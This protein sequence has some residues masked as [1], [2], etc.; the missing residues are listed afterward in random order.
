MCEK[1]EAKKHYY[2]SKSDTTMLLI[3][4]M[5]SPKYTKNEGASK[6]GTLLIFFR[7]LC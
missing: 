6:V 3:I 4:E 2:G 1:I 7:I 5:T